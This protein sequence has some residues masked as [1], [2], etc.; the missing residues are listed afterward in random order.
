[1][2]GKRDPRPIVK[3]IVAAWRLLQGSEEDQAKGKA[4]LSD[5]N[6][7]GGGDIVLLIY[8]MRQRRLSFRGLN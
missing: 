2:P 7:R 1:M 8:Q 6:R 5:L 4:I 3:E